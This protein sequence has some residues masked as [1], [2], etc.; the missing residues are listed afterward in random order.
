[1]LRLQPPSQDDNTVQTTPTSYR[2]LTQVCYQLRAEYRALYLAITTLE[3][4]T[5]GDLSQMLSVFFRNP[6]D[7]G[8]DPDQSHGSDARINSMTER[9]LDLTRLIKFMAYTPGVRIKIATGACR[10]HHQ[11][12]QLNRVFGHL[13]SKVDENWRKMILEAVDHVQFDFSEDATRLHFRINRSNNFNACYTFNDWRR[14]R[15]VPL[16]VLR[17]LPSQSKIVEDY[18]PASYLHSLPDGKHLWGSDVINVFGLHCN[19]G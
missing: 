15:D 6:D 4:D 3:L 18:E 8:D 12:Y 9:S 11:L 5:V 14:D 10:Q 7:E 2:G 13:S 19:E 17:G 1:M 16:R